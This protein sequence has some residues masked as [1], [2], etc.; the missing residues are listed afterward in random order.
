MSEETFVRELG[1][2]AEEVA[3]APLDFEAVRGRAV[4]IRRRRRLGAAVAVVAV[5]AAVVAPFALAGGPDDSAPDPAPAPRPAPGSSVLHDRV[6]TR[7]DGTTVRLDVD[8]ADVL[9]LGVLTDGRVVAALQEPYAIR[10][11]SPDGAV[12]AT[13][14]P[15]YNTITMS[16]SDN[17][18][19]WVGEDLRVR[20]LTSGTAEPA[21]LGAIPMPGDDAGSIDAVVDPSHLL[22][23]DHTTTTGVLTPDGITDLAA[24]EP[25]R[26]EDVSPDGG[27]WA[28]TFVPTADHEQYGCFGL[29]DPE[30][31]TITQRACDAAPLGCAPVG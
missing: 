11:Y 17:A 21:V 13:Y 1:R 10:V 23:G 30:A 12:Q 18:A 20:V 27:L 14:P 3:G 7:P 2:R 5:V 31:G 6:L 19:A 16:A 25:F 8:N 15:A 28:V 29:Y 24:P 22:V 4:R 26:V 9:E